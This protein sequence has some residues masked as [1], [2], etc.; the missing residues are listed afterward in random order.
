MRYANILPIVL[1][2]GLGL[3]ACESPHDEVNSTCM[4]GNRV[5]AMRN[6]DTGFKPNAPECAPIILPSNLNAQEQEWVDPAHRFRP[7]WAEDEAI[8]AAAAAEA[9]MAPMADPLM[10]PRD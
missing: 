1:L 4:F 9:P 8:A 10:V 2:V 7:G 5:Y 3:A 6:G